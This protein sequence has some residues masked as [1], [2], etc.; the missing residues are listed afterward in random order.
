MSPNTEFNTEV[1][2]Y[3]SSHSSTFVKSSTYLS[4][5][6]VR[7]YPSANSSPGRFRKRNIYATGRGDRGISEVEVSMTEVEAQD[8]EKEVGEVE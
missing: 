7:I 4:T 2:L 5:V 8:V 1:N 6:V 3:R